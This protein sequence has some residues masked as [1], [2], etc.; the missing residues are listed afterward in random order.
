MTDK[1]TTDPFSMFRDMVSQW[2]Q[3]ANDYG[4]KITSTSEFA[5]GMQGA[6]AIS[7]Q[8]QQAVQDG[9]TKVLAAAN[10]PSR[11]DI[12]AL[13]TRVAAIEVQLHRIVEALGA[14]S[15]KSSAPKPKRTKQPPSGHK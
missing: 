8:I 4:S 5:Q 10:I 7:L 14:Q 13:S 2:E 9:M 15:F 1:P 6:T 3:A 12:A 11:D